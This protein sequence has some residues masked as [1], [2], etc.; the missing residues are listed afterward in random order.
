MAIRLQK[1][2]ACHIGSQGGQ[3]LLGIKSAHAIARVHNDV[4]TAQGALII[5]RIYAAANHI[6][7]RSGIVVHETDFFHL[8]CCIGRAFLLIL[9]KKE[10]RFDIRALQ[11]APAGKKFQAVALPWVMAGCDLHSCITT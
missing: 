1:L 8:A 7:Q 11:A 2:A 3:H 4:V 9:R 5:I 10:D 6:P